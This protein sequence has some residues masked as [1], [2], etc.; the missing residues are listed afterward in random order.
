MS[1]RLAIS[2]AHRL[3][4][5]RNASRI[6]VLEQG[7]VMGLGTHKELLETCPTYVRLWEA[8]EGFVSA[9]TFPGTSSSRLPVAEVTSA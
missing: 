7:Q 4:T 3:S 6:L 9:D 8:Q 1:G 2:V 5:L